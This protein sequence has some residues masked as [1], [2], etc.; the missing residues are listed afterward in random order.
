LYRDNKHYV[1][2]GGTRYGVIGKLLGGL[3]GAG[4]QKRVDEQFEALIENFK[5]GDT[6]IDIVGYSRGAAIARMFTRH[7]DKNYEDIVFEG[8]PL[9]GPPGVRFLG[10]FD[11]V[12]SFG[13]PWTESEHDFET[14]ILEFVEHAYHAMALD[15]TRETFGIERCLG[16]R[17][18]ITADDLILR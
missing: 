15:E 18:K 1:N 6:T 14:N 9:D 17:D 2:V 16:N 8:K 5:V 4:A 3:T 11:T 12:A 13:V 7:I 10:L